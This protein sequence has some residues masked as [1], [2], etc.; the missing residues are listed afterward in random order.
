MFFPLQCNIVVDL[1]L[2][3]K[4]KTNYMNRILDQILMR[5]YQPRKHNSAG[6]YMCA[7]RNYFCTDFVSE[8]IVFLRVESSYYVFMLMSLLDLVRATQSH[9]ITMEEQYNNLYAILIRKYNIFDKKNVI[10]FYFTSTSFTYKLEMPCRIQ[11]S[12]KVSKFSLI[13]QKKEIK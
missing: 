10:R 9:K 5:I 2:Y 6:R 13:K 11:V 1:L 8:N 12:R 4:K 3:N 7:F